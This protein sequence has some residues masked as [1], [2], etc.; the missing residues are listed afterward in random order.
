MMASLDLEP[1]P[2][3]SPLRLLLRVNV[4][5]GWR[6]LKS[7]QEQST[8]LTAVILLFISSYLVLAFWLFFIGLRFIGKF[9]ALGPLLIERLLFLLFAFLFLLLLLSNLSSATQ[10]F[11]AIARPR[12]CSA[13]RC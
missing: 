9:P 5:S 11:F 13:C 1:S 3:C 8:L 2:H 4:L 7:L 10:T 12:S 6:R